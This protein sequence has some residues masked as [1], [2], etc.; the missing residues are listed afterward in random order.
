MSFCFCKD[1]QIPY[2]SFTL[3]ACRLKFCLFGHYFC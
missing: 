3:N 1:N 2:N